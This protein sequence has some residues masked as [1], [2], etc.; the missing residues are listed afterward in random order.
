ML[1]AAL[2]GLAYPA[3]I[4]GVAQLVFPS[5]ANGS[6]I[7]EGEPRRRLRA[8]RPGLR[9]PALFRRTAFGGG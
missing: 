8:D 4:T 6:L 7:R 9:Q 1:F 5:Q 3:A 2:L